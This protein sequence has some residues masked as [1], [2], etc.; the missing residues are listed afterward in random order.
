MQLSSDFGNLPLIFADRIQLQQVILNL[1]MNA[2]EAMS[3]NTDRRRE[4]LVR[5]GVDESGGIMVAVRDSGPGVAPEN[6]AHLFTPFYTTKPQGMGM[7]LAICRSIIEA[8]GGRLWVTNDDIGATFQF[9]LP[10]E[11]EGTPRLA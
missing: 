5:T 3:E 4:L 9:I 8:H 6:L 2:V 11:G 1:L 10:S 7:G